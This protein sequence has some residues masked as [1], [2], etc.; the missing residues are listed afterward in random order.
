MRL[1]V[2]IHADGRGICVATHEHVR[3]NPV[4]WAKSFFPEIEKLD[5]DSGAKPLIAAH[6][7]FVCEL[8]AGTEVLRDIDT[9]EAL[10]ALRAGAAI[11]AK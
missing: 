9:P 10:A 11:P 3:G 4:L 8:E 7:D 1:P 2:F 6:E 5:G